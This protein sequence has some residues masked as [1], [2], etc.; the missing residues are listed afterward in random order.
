[1][2]IIVSAEWLKTCGLSRYEGKP[3]EVIS[4]QPMHGEEKM[5]HVINPAGGVWAVWSIRGVTIVQD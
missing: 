4:V 2:K 1:M 3:M 5:Y